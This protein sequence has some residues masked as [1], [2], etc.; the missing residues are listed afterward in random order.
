MAH[1]IYQFQLQSNGELVP[2]TAQNPNPK[3]FFA[4]DQAINGRLRD[5]AV[6]NDGQTIY[7][8]NN[9]GGTDDKITVYQYDTTS[10]LNQHGSPLDIQL[11]PNPANDVL[12]ING[13]TEYSGL[14]TIQISSVLGQSIPVEFDS[15]YDINIS[16]LENGVH[17]IHLIFEDTTYSLKFLKMN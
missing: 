10:S 2:S 5:I 15:Q 16:G 7:L 9:G 13:L 17:F 6:S 4:A 8:I 12:S 1:G 11:F 14:Q 3:R